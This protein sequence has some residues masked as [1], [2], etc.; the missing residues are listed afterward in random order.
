MKRDKEI[1]TDTAPAREEHHRDYTGSKLGMW[2]FLLTEIVLFSG[3]FIV[4]AAGRDRYPVEF[5]NASL[6]LNGTL[7][8][9]NTVILLTSSLFVALSITA[10]Q[11]GQKKLSLQCLGLTIVFALAFLVN[12]Y[13]E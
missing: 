2:L 7:G 8:T 3:A 10:I 9:L 11:R 6:E 5:H 1:V 13:F 4:Y 12:K